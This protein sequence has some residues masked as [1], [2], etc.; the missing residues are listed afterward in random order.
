MSA[1]LFTIPAGVLG[2]KAIPVTLGHALTLVSAIGTVAS[3]FGAQS[4]AEFNARAAEQDARLERERAALEE[5]RLRRQT[6]KILG[7]QRAAFSK[8]GVT[9]EGTPLLVQEETAAEAELDAL[10]VR[11][12]GE[13][14]A[15]REEAR[16]RAERFGGRQ[17]LTAGLFGAGRTLLTGFGKRPHGKPLPKGPFPPPSTPRISPF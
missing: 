17:A 15:A 10:V 11:F 3:G 16:A 4:A 2:A 9:L 12:G 13:I 7:M 1:T 14:G 5:A 8:A 6:G